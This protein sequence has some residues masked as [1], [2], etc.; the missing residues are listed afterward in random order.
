MLSPWKEKGCQILIVGAGIT[1]LTL[2]REF[3]QRGAEDILILEKETSLGVH[4]SG[5]NSGVLHAG[6][7][8]TPGTLKAR[9][10]AEGNRLMKEFCRE[11]GLTVKENGKVIVAKNPT[12]AE[13]LN[14]LKRRADQSG[15]RAFLIDPKELSEIEPYAVTC[16]KALFSPD[17]AVIRPHEVLKA[18]EAELIQSKKVAI[19]YG[20]AFHGLQGRRLVR[21]TNGVIRFEKLINAAGAYAD[22]IAH[23]FGLAKEYKILPVKGTYQKLVNH[24]AFLVRGNIYPVPDLRN[25]FLGV[26]LTRTAD[27]DVFVGPTA[28]PALGRENYGGLDGWSF[29]T[30]LILYRNAMLLLKNPAF[31]HAALTEPRNYLKRFIHRESKKLL[32]ALQLQDL[33]RTNKVGIRPQLIHWPTKQLVMDFVLLE[34]GDSFHIINAISPAFTSSMAFAKHVADRVMGLSEV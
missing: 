12:E 9:F 34:D 5:R 8:Y 26:H 33:V 24:R 28:I 19:S 7:Y 29:E 15:A 22:Q 20:T 32:P 1:G 30:P 27:D 10:C 13:R 31:R 23:R 25:P 16:D 14:D 3:L 4:A 11:K 17:T 18:L 2:A 6:I 21:T